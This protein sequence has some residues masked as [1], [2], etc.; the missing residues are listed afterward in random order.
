MSGSEIAVIQ[1]TTNQPSEST[2]LCGQQNQIEIVFDAQ[3]NAE[4]IQS[5]WPDENQVIRISRENI[6]NFLDRLC[7]A[8]GILS[9]GG[10][11]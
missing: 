5:A 10:G 1:P 3:G 9:V 6:A 8:F 4:L 2:V 11:K 7:D